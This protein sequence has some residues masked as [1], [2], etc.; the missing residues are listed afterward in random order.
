MTSV[1]TRSKIQVSQIQNFIPS[2]DQ[3][4]YFFASQELM[5]KLEAIDDQIQNEQLNTLQ[6]D[7]ILSNRHNM[8]FSDDSDDFDSENFNNSDNFDNFDNSDN[9]DNCDNSDNSTTS[10]KPLKRRQFMQLLL[11]RKKRFKNNYHRKQFGKRTKKDI[12]ID[13][14][15]IDTI[16][17][18]HI[19]NAYKQSRI[20][21]NTRRA[22][23]IQK[24][25][26]EKIIKQ[27][28]NL[29][30]QSIINQNGQLIDMILLD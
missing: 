7:S 29:P 16:N 12:N 22:K 20:S 28:S 6:T 8:L 30:K 3:T 2:L 25:Y 11:K 15:I 14:D 23:K 27:Y 1:S 4:P 9:C 18:V 5:P 17:G 24:S 13:E 26:N 10:N 21:R 19:H